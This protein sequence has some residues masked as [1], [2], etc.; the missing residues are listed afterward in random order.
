[1]ST[2]SQLAHHRI[3][4]DRPV[5]NRIS[6]KEAYTFKDETHMD[7]DEIVRKAKSYLVKNL[8]PSKT[9][10]KIFFFNLFPILKWLPKYE[11]KHDTVKDLL[12]GL[13]VGSIRD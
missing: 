9:C 2:S 7:D 11:I 4:V 13:T 5:H 6:F 12:A 3:S 10:M 1:M 8:K